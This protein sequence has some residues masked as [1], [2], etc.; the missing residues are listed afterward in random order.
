[1]VRNYQKADCSLKKQIYC[2]IY[3][4]FRHTFVPYGDSA[5][6]HTRVSLKLSM[7][8]LSVTANEN[9]P[10]IIIK[11]TINLFFKLQAAFW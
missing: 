6:T 4:N 9:V 10:K 8:G 7:L 2:I 1:M 3:H 11:D 5:V